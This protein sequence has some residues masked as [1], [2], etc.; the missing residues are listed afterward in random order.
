MWTPRLVRVDFIRMKKDRSRVLSVVSRLGLVVSTEEEKNTNTCDFRLCTALQRCC[1]GATLEFTKNKWLMGVESVVINLPH[2]ENVYFAEKKKKRRR[3]I[4]ASKETPFQFLA[5]AF[6]V[7]FN[8]L[9]LPEWGLLVSKW[10]FLWALA[11]MLRSSAL[12]GKG[13]SV[14]GR[15]R[16]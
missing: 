2:W 1:S 10:S 16:V 13:L 8:L 6:Q 15:D 7:F 14:H 3:K 11:A 5:R 9:L 4:K 12:K